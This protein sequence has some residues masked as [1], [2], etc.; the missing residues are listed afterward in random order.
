[1]RVLI[2]IL[3]CVLLVGCKVSQSSQPIPH[4]CSRFEIDTIF[5]EGEH[6]HINEE[7]LCGWTGDV[8]LITLE[9][10]SEFYMYERDVIFDRRLQT[11][12]IIND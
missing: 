10:D 12:K 11:W 3:T 1:M 4:D 8:A 7:H 5:I 6:I 9:S 2:I